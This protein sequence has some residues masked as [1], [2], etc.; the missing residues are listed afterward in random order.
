MLKRYCFVFCF[1]MFFCS[2]NMAFSQENLV[3]NG[4]FEEYWECP[5]TETMPDN[6]QIERCKYWYAPT[7]GT[8]DFFHA[9][10][11][12]S[13]VGVPINKYGYQLPY[14]GN[15]YIG[16]FAMAYDPQNA[17]YD[18]R[19]YIQTKLE[20]PLSKGGEYYM[21]FYVNKCNG[22][23]DICLAIDR[24]GALFTDYKISSDD[25]YY[26]ILDAIP[27]ISNPRHNIITDTLNWTKISGT[28]IAK[29][30]EIYLTIGNFYSSDNTD[31]LLCPSM[32]PSKLAYY[33]IDGVLLKHVESQI[34]IP[35]VFTPNNDGIN[36]RFVIEHK[37][38][39]EFELN[40]RT[41]WGNSVYSTN[42]INEYWDGRFKNSDCPDGVYYYTIKAKGAEGK[43]YNLN[44]TIQL[45]R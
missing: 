12:P 24:F 6:P 7:V 19:E 33:Y 31:M 36:D 28:F 14:D 44:G 23:D 41:R 27:Q 25:P 30:G 35:N 17:N 20:H 8:P 42:D 2:T 15:G 1:C 21:E 16:V 11:N 29:G 22:D 45:I 40:I 43:I 13:I 37:S 10:A 18:W 26:L 38:I 9:C 34:N 32:S 4:S 3:R 39:V 5:Y